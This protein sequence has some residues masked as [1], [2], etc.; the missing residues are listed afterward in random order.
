MNPTRANLSIPKG[1]IFIVEDDPL[2]AMGYLKI[3]QRLAP[4]VHA[5]NL[6]DALSQLELLKHRKSLPIIAIIDLHLGLHAQEGLKV[7]EL[8]Q[9]YKVPCF[10]LSSNNDAAAIEGA[11]RLGCRHFLNKLAVK[12]ELANYLTQFFLTQGERW[13]ELFQQELITNDPQLKNS[14]KNLLDQNLVGQTIFIS[15]ETGTGKSHLAKFLHNHQ[16]I[17]GD[18]LSLH[19]AE[20]SENLIESEL[21]GHEKGAFTGADKSYEGRIRKSHEGTLFLDEVATLSSHVQIKLL[22]AIDE[23]IVYP[24]GGNKSYPSNFTLMAASWENIEEK[25]KAGTFREDLWYRLLG[26]SIEIPP[27]RDRR[28]DIDLLLQHFM[29]KLPRKFFLTPSAR[30]KLMNYNWPGNVRELQKVVKKL[31]FLSKGIIEKDDIIL[32][33]NESI[34]KEHTSAMLELEKVKQLGLPKF[35]EQ[36]EEK[37]VRHYL[38]VEQASINKTLRDLK[39]SSARFYR[40]QKSITDTSTYT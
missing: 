34:L 11:Y 40:I 10:V 8:C 23:K 38:E 32:Q 18:F 36:I 35:L 21:F 5:A 26:H 17:K 39:L 28:A 13:E 12:E 19:C 4:V 25:V 6:S 14:I 2:L 22:K 31:S 30:E 27:L 24:V 1:P 20:I 37:Y 33:Q 7:V 9:E 29:E 3:A 15:G 16:N